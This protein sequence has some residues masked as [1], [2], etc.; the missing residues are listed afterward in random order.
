M[1]KKNVNSLSEQRKSI[2][3][4]T[5]DRRDETVRRANYDHQCIEESRDPSPVDPPPVIDLTTEE[6]TPQV[7]ACHAIRKRKISQSSS[8]PS[9]AARPN[10]MSTSK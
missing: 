8:D 4:A 5:R 3:S 9:T 2:P 7:S 1:Y 6:D 10:K